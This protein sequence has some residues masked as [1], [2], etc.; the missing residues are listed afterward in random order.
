MRHCCAFL[1]FIL[2]VGASAFAQG[3]GIIQC[4]P[5]SK[6]PVPSWIAPGRPHVIEQLSCGQMVSVVGME[7]GYVKIQIADKPAYVDAKYVRILD[8]SERIPV[9]AGA[10]K[11]VAAKKPVPMEDDEQNKWKVLTKEN[12]EI[13][14]EKLLNPTHKNGPRTFTATIRNKSSFPVSHLQLLGRLYDCA[15]TPEKDNSNCDIIG[16]V[17][18]VVPISVPPGQ[19][20]RLAASMMF[21]S[22]PR[23][24]GTFAWSYK[25]LGVRVE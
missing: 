22:T 19:T 25:I 1:F 2:L 14:D 11:N 24:K 18:P 20:R 7:R 16:E 13:R 17:R 5:G 4:D 10:G 8:A 9:D 3:R 15:G 21:E 6:I 23:A 12:V